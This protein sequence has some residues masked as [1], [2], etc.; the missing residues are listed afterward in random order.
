MHFE[1]SQDMCSSASAP[2]LLKDWMLLELQRG[3]TLQQHI[4]WLSHTACSLDIVCCCLVV[5][6][7]SLHL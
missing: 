1:A 6:S 3:A 5:V 7:C 2:A 4:R